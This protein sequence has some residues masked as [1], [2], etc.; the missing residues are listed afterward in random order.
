M[1]DQQ[2]AESA[3]ARLER[4]PESLPKKTLLASVRKEVDETDSRTDGLPAALAQL[5]SRGYQFHNYLGART[6]RWQSTG[7]PAAS[8]KGEAQ[9]PGSASLHYIL[10]PAVSASACSALSVIAKTVSV[11]TVSAM[12]VS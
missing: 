5:R 2:T 12:A 6:E 4:Q 1:G 11:A 3:V 9:L 8:S 7:R 10:A